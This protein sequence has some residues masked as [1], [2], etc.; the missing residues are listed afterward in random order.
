M[1]E[2]IVGQLKGQCVSPSPVALVPL[3]YGCCTGTPVLTGDGALPIE[4]LT[5]GD[6]IITRDQGMIRLEGTQRFVASGPIVAMRAGALGG[7]MPENR[8]LLLPDQEVLVR[9][10]RG[11]LRRTPKGRMVSA[12]ELVDGDAVQWLD[13]DAEY[14]M[15]ALLFSAPHVIYAG[16]LELAM[17]G[18][19]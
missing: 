18:T 8:M 19:D 3:S 1:T 4:W 16:G 6:R 13:R 10:S 15:I 7:V 9:E 11:L 17:A 5:E 2:L 14:E 12:A